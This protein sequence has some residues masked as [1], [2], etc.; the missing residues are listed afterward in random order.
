MLITII[1][2]STPNFLEG[3]FLI[4]M[5]VPKSEYWNGP[6]VKVL[7]PG[8]ELDSATFLGQKPSFLGTLISSSVKQEEE[9]LPHEVITRK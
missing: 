6:K 3:W 9:Y 2:N 1:I 4:R 5:K 7:R 8:Y